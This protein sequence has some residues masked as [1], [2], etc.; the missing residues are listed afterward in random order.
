MFRK[1]GFSFPENFVSIYGKKKAA[2]PEVL[3]SEYSS[4]MHCIGIAPFAKHR[5]KIYPEKIMQ[6]L[7]SMLE[8]T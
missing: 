8:K 4:E 6:Q 3:L 5:G 1:L 7:L 2:L